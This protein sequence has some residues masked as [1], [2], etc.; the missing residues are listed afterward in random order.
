[1]R[2]LCSEGGGGGRG[3]CCECVSGEGVH[4][5]SGGVHVVSGGVHVVSGEGCML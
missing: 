3:A 1:M 2:Y 4:V 5:V